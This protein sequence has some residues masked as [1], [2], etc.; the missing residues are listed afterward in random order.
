MKQ[1]AQFIRRIGGPTVEELQAAIE[2]QAAMQRFS[3]VL[4]E[5][6]KASEEIKARR[7]AST[8]SA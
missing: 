5:A 2:L 8:Q 7:L 1:I 4:E 6:R 3:L